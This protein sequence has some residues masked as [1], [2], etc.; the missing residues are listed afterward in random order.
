MSALLILAVLGVVWY[1]TT[2]GGQDFDPVDDGMQ[3]DDNY[4]AYVIE[5]SQAISVAE[6]W[7]QPGAIPTVRNN[8]GDIADANGIIT[9]PSQL[10][11]WAAL[12]RQVEKMFDGTSKYYNPTMT[13]SEIA[14]KYTATEQTAW[15][16]NVAAQLGFGFTPD[17]TLNEIA[18][19]FM[20]GGASSA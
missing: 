3:H 9:F 14:A 6:G 20:D 18:S 19:F 12:H 1:V 13:I 17:S 15:A 4:P 8:P 2:Q 11:G 5:F 16:S 7:G 10:D